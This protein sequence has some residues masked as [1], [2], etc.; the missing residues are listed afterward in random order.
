M[1]ETASIAHWLQ[2]QSL[3]CILLVHAINKNMIRWASWRRLRSGRTNFQICHIY[4]CTCKDHILGKLAIFRGG[5]QDIGR[6]EH[7]KKEDIKYTQHALAFDSNVSYRSTQT[8]PGLS[9]RRRKAWSPITWSI[10]S[11]CQRMTTDEKKGLLVQITKM[12]EDDQRWEK[13][14]VHQSSWGW[15]SDKRTRCR[16]LFRKIRCRLS[17]AQ[18]L[19]D[20]TKW[21]E[22]SQ[23][24]GLF[25]YVVS[26]WCAGLCVIVECSVCFL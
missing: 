21:W 2:S 4:I 16:S 20:I 22:R 3:I 12:P 17:C 18:C 8:R 14:P 23:H 7:Q 6:A 15:E 26:G 1:I 5:W 19:K 9:I 10:I 25:F 13:G 24:D 11:R